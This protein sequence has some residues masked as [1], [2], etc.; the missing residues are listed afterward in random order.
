VGAWLDARLT[1][2]L[3]GPERAVCQNVHAARSV[4]SFRGTSLPVR[5]TPRGCGHTDASC[6]IFRQIAV[7]S[8]GTVRI[9]ARLVTLRA[10]VRTDRL[11]QVRR[12]QHH[13]LRPSPLTIA[14]RSRSTTSRAFVRPP[15]R[16]GVRVVRVGR[17]RSRTARIGSATRQTS[18]SSHQVVADDFA[19]PTEEDIGGRSWWRRVGSRAS[20]EALEPRQGPVLVAVVTT[21]SL[22]R[23][24]P[25]VPRPRTRPRPRRRARSGVEPPTRPGSRRRRRASLGTPAR[26]SRRRRRPAPARR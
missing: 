23:R 18:S 21:A 3:I 9:L 8:Q 6:E 26:R 15:P 25:A 12:R 2:P 13:A 11:S 5:I 14:S 1:K 10:I 19:V 24:S 22:R 20:T 4:R 17:C 16:M 7:K